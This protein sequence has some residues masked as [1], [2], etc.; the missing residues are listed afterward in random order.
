MNTS[1]WWELTWDGL[2]S[3]PGG[4]KDSHPLNTTETGDKRWLHGPLGSS[5][6][7]CF[8]ELQTQTIH[9]YSESRF[10]PKHQFSWIW[11]GF[12]SSIN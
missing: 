5:T 6:G 11:F 7:V 9:S 8:L 12:S 4:V 2:V 10:R 1:N 3:H